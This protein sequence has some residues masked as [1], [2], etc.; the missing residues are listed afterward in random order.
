[1]KGGVQITKTFVVRDE[2]SEASLMSYSE[3]L[4]ILRDMWDGSRFNGFIYCYIFFLPSSF[5]A[6]L[7]F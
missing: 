4:E 2:I 3:N 7:H 1:M 5:Y 6:E